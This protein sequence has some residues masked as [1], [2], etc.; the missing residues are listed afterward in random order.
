MPQG[1]SPTAPINFVYIIYLFSDRSDEGE[2]L[3]KN[4]T[5]NCTAEEF[6]CSNH[7][8]IP[9]AWKCDND[10]DCGDGSDEPKAECERLECPKGWSKELRGWMNPYFFIGWSRCASSYR[11]VPDWAFC[12]GQ[13]DC[14]DGSDEMPSRC[15]ACEDQ[16]EFRCATTGKCI[17][18]RWMCDSEND[19][20][21][22]SDEIDEEC[23]GTARPCSESGIDN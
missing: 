8:C 16:G 19:C 1:P 23:G 12:N 5:R 7:K 22:N 3:C 13:D 18:R 20:G 2:T 11:C 10:D 9:K 17:P 4:P 21:D 15:P 6:R 14:R